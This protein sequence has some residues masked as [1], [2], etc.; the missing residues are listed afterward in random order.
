MTL[1]HSLWI[2]KAFG[3]YSGLAKKSGGVRMSLMNNPKVLAIVTL[4][5][6][7]FFI[8]FVK[9]ISIKSQY[10]FVTI[11]FIF[12]TL[13]F[14]I[15]LFITQKGSV[16]KQIRT[17][18]FRVFLIGL[19]G[20]FIYYIGLIQ[21]LREFSST[22]G[23]SVLN[24]TWPIFTVIFTELVFSRKSKGLW[25]RLIET[26]GLLLG[27]TSVL[28]L[29]TNGDIL[30]LDFPNIKGL[31]W[32]L[33]AGSSYGF[34]SAYFSRVP[35]ESRVAFLLVSVAVSLLFMLPFGLNELHSLGAITWKDLGAIVIVGVVFDGVGYFLWTSANRTAEEKDVGISAVVSIILFLPLSSVILVSIFYQETELFQS[36]FVVVLALLVAGSLLCNQAK[37]IAGRPKP[38]PAS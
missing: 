6:W 11:S 36:Y 15:G 10:L 4:V 3:A 17:V 12:T 20:Y 29:A 25:H 21:C 16:K 33:V 37:K 5:L 31:L 34:F 13:T 35:K 32:G 30:A 7:S 18:K 9:L 26:I 27:C 19:S 23:S 8:P 28:I 2:E 1:Y 14:L 22:S 24:Y 38:G